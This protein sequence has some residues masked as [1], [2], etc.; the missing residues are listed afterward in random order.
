MIRLAAAVVIAVGLSQTLVHAQSAVFTVGAEPAE[1][2]MSP[3]NGSPVIGTAR[4]GSVLDVRR[5]LG[6]WVAIPWPGARDGEAFVHQSR[7][8]LTRRAIPSGS[9]AANVSTA[10]VVERQTSPEPSRAEQNVGQPRSPLPPVYVTP[11]HV[12][13]LGLRMGGVWPGGFGASGRM[14]SN[15]LGFQLSLSRQTLTNPLGAER[16]TSVR[17]DPSVLY[18][19]PDQVG[20]YVWVRPYVG[21]GVSLYRHTLHSGTSILPLPSDDGVA[22]QGFGGAEMTFAGAPAVAVSV[23]LGYRWSHT[24]V[25]GFDLTGPTLSLSG[26][27][28]LK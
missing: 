7:G 2:Y 20:D 25:P 23:D 14:W 22:V 17:I 28:Y 13:G 24:S 27:W 8:S 1:V 9:S 6:S 3:S 16:L 5:E 12:I 11:P 10:P 26:H 19:V 4:V 15:A 18:H 21:S